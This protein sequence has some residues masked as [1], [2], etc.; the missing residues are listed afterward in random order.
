[1]K[2]HPQARR[3]AIWVAVALALA[4]VFAS[5]LRPDMAFALI[6]QAWGCL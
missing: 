1:V 2:P 5:W 4:L 6:S 3:I